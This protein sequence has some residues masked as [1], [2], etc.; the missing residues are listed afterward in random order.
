MEVFGGFVEAIFFSKRGGV[1]DKDYGADVLWVGECA[2]GV[3][4]DFPVAGRVE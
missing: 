4:T 3:V 1:Y 2:G